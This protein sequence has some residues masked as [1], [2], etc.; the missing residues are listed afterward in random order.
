LEELFIYEF[1]IN[2]KPITFEPETEVIPAG[3]TADMLLLIQKGNILIGEM[4][5]VNNHS[6]TF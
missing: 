1:L 6:P 5:E 2:L 4:K 3:Q